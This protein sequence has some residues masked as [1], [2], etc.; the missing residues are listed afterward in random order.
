MRVDMKLRGAQSGFGVPKVLA[1]EESWGRIRDVRGRWSHKVK[2][3]LRSEAIA[4]AA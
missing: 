4:R 2:R 3:K 1:Q